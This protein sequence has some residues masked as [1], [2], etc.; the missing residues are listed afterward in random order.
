MTMEPLIS[1]R[2][3]G[4]SFIPYRTRN[5]TIE[6]YLQKRSQ[7]AARAP[8]MLGMF[9]GGLEEGESKE[10]ALVRE[11]REELSYLPTRH[12]YFSRY[13]FAGFILHI[14]IEEAEEGF[15]DAVVIGEGEY[16]RFFSLEDI[17]KGP[18][19]APACRVVT[20]QL[21]EYLVTGSSR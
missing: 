7:D 21:E 17:R 15:E 18:D 16:G 11:L 5:G 4:A 19:V 6:F 9:G 12:R 1:P 10:D 2:R 13:E 8:G 3:E 20:A 14:F